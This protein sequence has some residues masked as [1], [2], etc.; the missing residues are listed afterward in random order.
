MVPRRD[1]DC[2][3]NLG[4]S[5]TKE[6]STRQE[7]LVAKESLTLEGRTRYLIQDAVDERRE[8]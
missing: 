7:S 6:R 1:C 3:A 4:V 5:S 8:F 2:S